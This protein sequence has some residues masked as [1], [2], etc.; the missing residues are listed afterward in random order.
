MVNIDLHKSVFIGIL[1]EIYSNPLLRSVLGFKGGSAAMLFYDLPR[2]SVELD[3]DLLAPEKKEEVFERLKEMLPQFG[4]L[5]EATEKRYTLFFLLNYRKGERNLKLEI[6]KRPMKSEYHLMNY[7]G[8]SMLVMDQGDMVAGKLAA[9][10]TR[11]K[12]ASRDLFDTWFFLKNNWQINDELVKE[13][14]DMPL[15]VALQKA[16]GIAQSVKKTELLA[17]LGD[18]LD[19]KQKN[20]AREKLVDETIFYLS[21]Y[22]DAY[23]KSHRNG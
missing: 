21:L 9:L 14:T 1:R 18:L 19:N 11:K 13:K 16:Q 8:I 4:G 17:G 6:S 7:F 23:R 3:F 20:W 2:F 22:R 12:F 5:T 15:D 10:L